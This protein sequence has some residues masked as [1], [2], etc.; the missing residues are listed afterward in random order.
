MQTIPKI[1]NKNIVSEVN[2]TIENSP[3]EEGVITIVA[4]LNS[5]SL[6]L[7]SPLAPPVVKSIPPGVISTVT[8]DIAGEDP[9]VGAILRIVFEGQALQYFGLPKFFDPFAQPLPEEPVQIGSTWVREGTINLY[10]LSPTATLT[11]TSHFEVL[12]FKDHGPYRCV[13]IEMT[14]ESDLVDSQIV[15]VGIPGIGTAT[16]TATAHTTGSSIMYFAF[17]A[18]ETGELVGKPVFVRGNSEIITTM[19]AVDVD[20]GKVATADMTMNVISQFR[21]VF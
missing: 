21:E 1:L 17:E 14:T 9:G 8:R 12:S 2:M 6:E 7:T 15:E 18:I 19:R 20:T 10:H 11:H 3:V 13:K 16:F 5:G 4:T